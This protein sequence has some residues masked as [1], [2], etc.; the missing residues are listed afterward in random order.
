MDAK[1][2]TVLEL[3]RIV[4]DPALK[5]GRPIV[6]GTGVTVKRIAAWYQLGMAP[7][8]IAREVGHLTLAQVHAALSYYFDHQAE[9]DA[10][11]AEDVQAEANA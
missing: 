11:L 9:I 5:G 7:E 6:A 1:A 4:R 10:D 8:Q 3:P 2:V